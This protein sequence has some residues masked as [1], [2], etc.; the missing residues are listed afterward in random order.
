MQDPARDLF[1]SRLATDEAHRTVQ[2]NILH[3]ML[4]AVLLDRHVV[5]DQ[6]VHKDYPWC[7]WGVQEADC[8]VSLEHQVTMSRNSGLA[9]SSLLRLL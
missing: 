6:R 7:T 4:F 8:Y 3:A 5:R 9:M 1:W 2:Q